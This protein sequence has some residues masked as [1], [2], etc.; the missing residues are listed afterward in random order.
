MLV[1]YFTGLSVYMYE[2]LPGFVAG[3]IVMFIVNQ[4]AP[5]KDAVILAEY[6]E[7]KNELNAP[8]E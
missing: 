4:I 2:I 1:W 5:Q 3:L 7:M 6:D 8:Q